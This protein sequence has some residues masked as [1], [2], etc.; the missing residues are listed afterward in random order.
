MSQIAD[1]IKNGL[2][3]LQVAAGQTLSYRVNAGDTWHTFTGFLLPGPTMMI[4]YDEN[5]NAIMA[6]ET[7]RLKVPT[8]GAHLKPGSQGVIGA[9]V[10]DQNG[11]VWAVVGNDHSVGQSLYTLARTPL[12]AQGSS[13]GSTP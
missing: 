1:A 9:Q 11:T 13:R 8:D 4:G 5:H 12:T 7:A 3:L 10:K 6:P 2:S